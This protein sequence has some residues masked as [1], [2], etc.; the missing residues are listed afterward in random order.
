[1]QSLQSLR[2]LHGEIAAW[3]RTKWTKQGGQLR[4]LN[5]R[6]VGYDRARGVFKGKNETGVPMMQHEHRCVLKFVNH[7]DELRGSTYVFH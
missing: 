7:A 3:D 6:R 4:Q 1:M 5:S 2:D